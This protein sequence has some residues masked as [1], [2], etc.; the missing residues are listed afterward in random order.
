MEKFSQVSY[1]E[2]QKIY[3]GLYEGKSQRA[4]ALSI[5]K[6]KSTVSREIRRNKDY[7][8]YL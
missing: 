7:I 3:T 8:G 5:G 1:Y 4:I 2:R 6:D